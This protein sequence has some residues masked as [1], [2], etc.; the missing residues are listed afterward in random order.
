[1]R[2][3]H[4]RLTS[5]LLILFL[6]YSDL[7]CRPGPS[8]HAW[9]P[10]VLYRAVSQS[11]LGG[12]SSNFHSLSLPIL[13]FIK[14]SYRL[15]N[16]N[17]YTWKPLKPQITRFFTTIFNFY[18]LSFLPHSNF[19]LKCHF[20]CQIEICI[21]KTSENDILLDFLHTFSIST[22]FLFIPTP[23]FC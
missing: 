9:K 4:A 7:H 16:Q 2:K 12:S 14:L 5:I 17:L 23:I 10:L 11:G 6:W 15:Y 1:M 3:S 18:P 19:L 20:V 21:S 13:F 22:R 8:A